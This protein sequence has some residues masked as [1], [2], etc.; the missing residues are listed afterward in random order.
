MLEAAVD[1]QDAA[2]FRLLHD[3]GVAAA[4]EDLPARLFA[5]P[6]RLEPRA[7]HGHHGGDGAAQPLQLSQV[8]PALERRRLSAPVGHGGRIGLDLQQRPQHRAAEDEEEPHH[9]HQVHQR[10]APDEDQC[11][12]PLVPLQEARG[13]VDPDAADLLAFLGDGPRRRDQVRSVLDRSRQRRPAGIARRRDRV[14]AGHLDLDPGDVPIGHGALDDPADLPVVDVPDG[15]HQQ[16]RQVIGAGVGLRPQGGPRAGRLDPQR[17]EAG[18]AQHQGDDRHEQEGD[19]ERDRPPCQ[20][21]GSQEQIQRGHRSHASWCGCGGRP[22]RARARPARA[23]YWNGPAPV[24]PVPGGCA[25]R[26]RGSHARTI[27]LSR[28]T[29]RGFRPPEARVT[30]SAVLLR[31]RQHRRGPGRPIPWR[32]AWPARAPRWPAAR[33]GTGAW[34]GSGSARTE[35]TGCARCGAPPGCRRSRRPSASSARGSA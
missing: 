23:A 16:A 31:R 35:R 13:G 5:L 17:D 7:Q 33:A 25:G 12:L 2:A 32:R 20:G 24:Q 18:H 9:Q 11:Q 26:A 10:D 4:L 27:S 1:L 28:R 14:P 21:G 29:R 15:K 19:V 22:G 3:D 30:R 34:P 6:E 8:A